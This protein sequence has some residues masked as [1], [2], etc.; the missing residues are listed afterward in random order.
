LNFP[1]PSTQVHGDLV[2][3]ETGVDTEVGTVVYRTQVL[4]FLGIPLGWFLVMLTATAVT[5]AV[6]AIVRRRTRLARTGRT[7]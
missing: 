6:V 7:Q 3:P 5:T 2:F 4:T 1:D